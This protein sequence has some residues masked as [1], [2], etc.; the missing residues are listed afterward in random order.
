MSCPFSAPLSEAPIEKTGIV[1]CSVE[2][3]VVI[4]ESVWVCANENRKKKTIKIVNI[5]RIKSHF[6]KLI[7]NKLF[8]LK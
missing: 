4:V 6:F 2:S 7:K 1:F 5:R 3:W 8:E